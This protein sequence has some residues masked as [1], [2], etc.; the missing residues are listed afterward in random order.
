MEACDWLAAKVFPWTE[1]RPSY[2][3][4]K[5]FKGKP[6]SRF[7]PS[8]CFVLQEAFVPYQTIRTTGHDRSL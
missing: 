2:V 3:S 5:V 4:T 7:C 6:T 1:N 8:N